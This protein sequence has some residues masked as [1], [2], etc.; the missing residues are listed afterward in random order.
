MK[1]RWGG[2]RVA[3]AMAKLERL[4]VRE[5]ISWSGGGESEGGVKEVRIFELLKTPF[6]V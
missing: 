6:L 5:E 3:M 2:D 1:D 4:I